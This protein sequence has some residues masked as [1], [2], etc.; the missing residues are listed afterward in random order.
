MAVKRRPALTPEDRER[1]MI[2]L[3]M[4]LAEEQLIKGT[5][6]TAV[7]THFI[8]AGSTRESLEQKKLNNENRLL[9]AKI[10]E[11]S[12]GREIKELYAGAIKAMRRY[13]GE[14]DEDGDDDYDA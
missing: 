3:A 8:K 6:S 2:G 7:I 12:Q 10:N 13:Q 5:A 9:D 4:D 1:Q 14:E 11:I